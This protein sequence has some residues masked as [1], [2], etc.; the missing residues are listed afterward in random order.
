MNNYDSKIKFEEIKLKSH[1]LRVDEKHPLELLVGLN[2]YGQKTIR[3]IGD[4]KKINIKGTKTIEIKHFKVGDSYIIS[5]SLVDIEYSDLFYLFC[6]DLIDSS[7]KTKQED[8]YEFIVNRYEK[9]RHFGITSRKY[10][11]ENEIKGLMGELLFMNETLFDKYGISKS[12]LAWT[13]TEPLKKDFSFNDRWYEIKTISKDIVTISSLEQL[14]SHYRGF[15]ILFS[16]EKLSPDAPGFRLNELVDE[17]LN[18]LLKESDKANFI[19]KL[20]QAGFYKEE[21]YDQF[22]YRVVK[23]SFYEVTDDFPMI[24][25]DILPLAIE[26]IRYDLI[27]NMLEEFKRDKI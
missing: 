1:Y 13:G 21:Y 25:K 15:L 17:I 11:T 8:G 3:F 20:V 19:L 18:K 22:V 23:S 14:D 24:K 26:N 6:N 9:W 12:I 10:L 27:V 7:R 2:D 5:F 4:F 16:L